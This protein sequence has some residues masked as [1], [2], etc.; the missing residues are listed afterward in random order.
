M[1]K[2]SFSYLSL[3]LT[4]FGL[5]ISSCND[6]YGLEKSVAI[7]QENKVSNKYMIEVD[8]A[9]AIASRAL[10]MFNG[11]MP[12]S[13]NASISKSVKEV[14]TYPVVQ[15]RSSDA[16][17]YIVNFEEG[18]FA[19]VPADSR[20]TDVYALSNEGEFNME[21]E[22]SAYVLDLAEAY[23]QEE[24][25]NASLVEPMATITP[26]EPITPPDG[27]PEMYLIV[28]Y[29]GKKYYWHPTDTQTTPFYL[30]ATKWHQGD[31]YRHFCFTDEGLNA[32]AGCESIALAQIM[33][34]HKKPES[35]NEHYYKW[36]FLDQTPTIPEDSWLVDEVGILVHDICEQLDVKYGTTLTVA[37][38]LNAL[39]TFR[40]FGYTASFVGVYDVSEIISSLNNSNP[41]YI[42][43][44]TAQSGIY[45]HAWVLDG[46]YTM[47]TIDVY[48]DYETL[49]KVYEK[50]TNTHYL[51][52]NWGYKY[53]ENCYCL[54][55]L[56]K[57]GTSTYDRN[58]NLIYA[59]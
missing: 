57:V 31:P 37:T 17:L 33:A 18:G 39:N 51:H 19:I 32:V 2:S 24:I 56:F 38:D 49:E 40:D 8:D 58:F 42:S 11:Q 20:A 36:Y 10:D 23:L 26:V 45:G 9:V 28:E 59:Q 48:Y 12:N 35:F 43:G 6:S 7:K 41:V 1:I 44:K 34:Y 50:T 3:L 13:R 5:F 46:Y 15:S 25:N 27:G 4:C 29:E 47:H 14:I 55:E 21:N 52:C 53:S 22:S 30:L 54:S 16:S